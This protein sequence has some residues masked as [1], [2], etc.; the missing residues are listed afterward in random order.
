MQ[1]DGKSADVD[2]TVAAEGFATGG[3]AQWRCSTNNYVL[4]CEC[5]CLSFAKGHGKS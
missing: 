5:V 3:E 2:Q 1:V 4:A